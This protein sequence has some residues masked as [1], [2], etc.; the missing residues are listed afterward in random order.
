MTEQVEQQLVVARLVVVPLDPA[1]AIPDDHGAGAVVALRDH[2]LEVEILDWM[3][4]G[5]DR[6]SFVGGIERGAVRY[7]PT[8]QY[9]VDLEAQVVVHAGRG[10]L[11]HDEVTRTQ[12][13]GVE[14]LWGAFSPSFRPVVG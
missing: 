12:A 6:Q 14:R 10:V 8:A 4:L 3:V 13:A 2:V 1:A 5:L 9:S 11:V 7:R